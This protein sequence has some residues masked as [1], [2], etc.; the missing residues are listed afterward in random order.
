MVKKYRDKDYMKY[1]DYYMILYKES[2][3]T[4][5]E[6][7]KKDPRSIDRYSQEHDHRY[8]FSWSNGK[9]EGMDKFKD[10]ELL[11]S[12]GDIRI[13]PVPEKK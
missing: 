4:N 6:Y 11:N 10:G 1:Q 12:S 5:E 9:F 8:T 13:G 7:I 3:Y 2:K